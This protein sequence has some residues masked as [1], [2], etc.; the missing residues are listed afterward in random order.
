MIDEKTISLNYIKKLDYPGSDAGIRYMMQAVLR[1]TPEEE[2]ELRAK[3][4]AEG[5]EYKPPKPNTLCVS[6]W[7]EPLSFGKTKPELITSKDFP[8]TEDGKKE[9]VDW[10]NAEKEAN[11]EKYKA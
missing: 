6:I 2:Q 8:L 9:A 11:P 7:P 4:E 5:K 10:I 1:I 3:A